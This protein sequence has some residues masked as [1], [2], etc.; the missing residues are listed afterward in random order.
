M[1]IAILWY[2][3]IVNS[4]PNLILLLRFNASLNQS[5]VYLCLLRSASHMCDD[6]TSFSYTIASNC[7]WNG[8]TNYM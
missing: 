8:N 1:L 2:A 4:N 3:A 5:L 6:I 7:C